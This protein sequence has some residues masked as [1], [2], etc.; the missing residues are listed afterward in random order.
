MRTETEAAD[1]D[2]D[3]GRSSYLVRPRDRREARFWFT[4]SAVCGGLGLWIGSTQQ[5]VCIGALGAGSVL[6]ALLFARSSKH[7]ETYRFEPELW[8][9][10]ARVGAGTSLIFYLIEYFPAHMEVHLEVNHP[11]ISLGWLGAGEIMYVLLMAK[12]DWP[13]V[14]ARAGEMCLRGIAWEWLEWP[15]YRWR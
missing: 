5:C 8:R 6:G 10:W 14:R 11:I 2:I 7:T 13:T 9:H 15:C 1:G 12:G 4:A 3:Q